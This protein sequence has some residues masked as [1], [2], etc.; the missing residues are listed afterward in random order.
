LSAV[1]AL[2]A[3]GTEPSSSGLKPAAEPHVGTTAAAK[4]TDLIP[5]ETPTMPDNAPDL[6]TPVPASK[7]LATLGA[8]CFWCVEAVYEQLPGV[9]GAVSG[10]MGGTVDKPTY[11]QVCGKKTGH[12]EVV[13]VEFDPRVLTYA[14]LLDWFWRLHD[15]TSMDKQGADS[16]PQYRSVVFFHSPEQE[17]VARESLA[18][19]QPS[20]SKPIVTEVRAASTFWIAEGVHQ[21]YYFDNPGA[22]YCR[23]VIAPKLDK[24]GLKK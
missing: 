19:A 14:E 6:S 5:T 24:L 10:Y 16:G 15:P 17:R 4:T 11:E 8:G 23:M 21:G 22:G 20:F 3:C 13:Q 12:V 2:S 9:H 1:L 7:E 18:A